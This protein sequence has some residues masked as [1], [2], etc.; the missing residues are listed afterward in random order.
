MLENETLAT[1]EV[2]ERVEEAPVEKT[3]ETSD[4]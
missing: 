4:E 3:A 1:E 2:V